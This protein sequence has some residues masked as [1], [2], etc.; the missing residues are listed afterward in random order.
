MSTSTQPNTTRTRWIIFSIAALLAMAAWFLRDP[1]ALRSVIRLHAAIPADDGATM[2][3]IATAPDIVTLPSVT[4]DGYLAPVRYALLSFAASNTVATVHVTEG[5]WVKA[6]APLIALENSAQQATL[7]QAEANLAQAQ[8]QLETV[9]AAARSEEIAQ[10]EAA[11]EVAT[12]NLYRLVDGA[13][14]EQIA[15]ADKSIAA[16]QASAANVQ[17]GATPQ[18]ITAAKATLRQAEASLRNAQS[19]YDK[20]AWAN[21]IGARP[22]SLRLE[23]ATIE[24]ER[25]QAQYDNVVNGATPEE[26]QVAWAQVAQAQAAKDE[27]L[28]AAHPADVAQA[29]ANIRSATAAL[30]LLRAGARPEEIAAA[31]AQVQAAQAAVQQAQAAL[32]AMLLTAP[33]A[34]QVSSVAVRVGEFVAPGATVVKLGDTRQWIVETDTLSELEVVRLHEGETV[35]VTFDAL[36]AASFRG[37]VKHIQPASDFKRGDVTFTATIALEIAD[38]SAEAAGLRWGMSASVSK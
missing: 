24:Y 8:A 2:S 28:A 5:D 34:G 25:A 38:D 15:R 19:A 13:T 36:P 14:S 3:E 37:T 6:G 7:A 17:A 16:A 9:Q 20:V 31:Q 22:E 30:D 29:Q 12:M 35:I 10:A 32:D 21:D 27:L 33:F 11:V 26:I 1:A 18:E 4:A 23:Q